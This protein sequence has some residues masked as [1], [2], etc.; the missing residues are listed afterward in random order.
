M[1]N[2]TSIGA[3][4]SPD[5]E[6]RSRPSK[7]NRTDPQD[8]GEEVCTAEIEN[9]Y[10][11]IARTFVENASDDLEGRIFRALSVSDDTSLRREA[12]RER[13]GQPGSFRAKTVSGV[14]QSFLTWFLEQ[15]DLVL[16]FDEF[17]MPVG[18]SYNREAALQ[19]YG[20]LCDLER[21][22]LEA[23]RQTGD[24][25]Y[26]AL[27]GI[28]ASHRNA[29]GEYR[30][31]ADHWREMRE[32][33]SNHVRQEQQ[34]IFN[35]LGA[36]RYNPENP[37]ER[38][39]EYVRIA[40]PHRSGFGHHHIAL[41]TNFEVSSQTFDPVIARHIEST[42]SANW[43]AH[44]L[45]AENPHERCVSVNKIDPESASQEDVVGNLASYLSGY[46]SEFDEA[47]DWVKM[48]EKPA[49]EVMFAATAWATGSR[50]ID[51]SNGAHKIKHL[52]YDLRPE[53]YKRF[54]SEGESPGPVAVKNEKSGEEYLILEPGRV[55]MYQVDDRPELDPEKVFVDGH[56]EAHR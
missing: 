23:C 45:T 40:E 31:P 25:L 36:D 7:A 14:M 46:L 47:G 41:V 28:T 56:L 21:G 54:E 16:R 26:T 51:F 8:N 37:P 38:W 10:S 42:P 44:D 52:G 15:E 13:R 43:A 3:V 6:S 33:W 1:S 39:W 48:T 34:R 53:E 24:T 17:D 29:N 9:T 30:C 32:S 22:A 49:A 18:S 2:Q 4:H 19:R 35:E 20:D 5:W 27:L 11:N 55:E 12:V 50:R